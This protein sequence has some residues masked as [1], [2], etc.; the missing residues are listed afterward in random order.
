MALICQICI[1]NNSCTVMYSHPS[2]T[3]I[4]LWLFV[5]FPL[6]LVYIL[7]TSGDRNSWAG[8]IQT[9]ARTIVLSCPAPFP[10]WV[11]LLY[12]PLLV[13][14]TNT[15]QMLLAKKRLLGNPR[16][17]RLN[18]FELVTIDSM[19]YVGWPRTGH[20]PGPTTSRTLGRKYV[21]L[22]VVH[23]LVSLSLVFTCNLCVV[24]MEKGHGQGSSWR[25]PSHN[26]PYHTSGHKLNHI[27]P[28]ELYLSLL[29]VLIGG[30]LPYTTICL[31][32]FD[33][34]RR[35][36]NEERRFFLLYDFV[37]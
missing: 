25:G 30:E 2:D 8:S 4:T 21:N 33:V 31:G 3:F 1:P 23:Q 13:N 24:G 29:Y 15:D 9:A 35:P 12:P 18:N 22:L 37:L 17:V 19:K 28:M 27:R 10:M 32:V 5:T 26:V 36:R 20:W 7:S 11:S 14:A 16:W 34:T 6:V